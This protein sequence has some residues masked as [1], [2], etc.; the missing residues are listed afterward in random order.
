[1]SKGLW[2]T[3]RKLT[4]KCYENMAGMAGAAVS[5]DCWDKAF[6]VLQDIVA[7]G[8]NERA[9]YASELYQLDEMTD[10]EYDVQGWMEDYLDELDMREEKG[11]IL[12]VCDTLLG[13]FRW[14]EDTP[15]EIKLKKAMALYGLGE[16]AAAV[17]FC[18][19]WLEK[20]PDNIVTVTASVYAYTANGDMKEAEELIQGHIKE[21]TQCTEEND[22]LFTAAAAYY[23]VSG[24][25]KAYKRIDDALE[26]YDKY[27]EEFFLGDGE[28]DGFEWDDDD[29][30]FN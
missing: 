23:K 19:H 26:A 30:P 3:F 6:E 13:M 14:K 17:D 4:G 11:K 22:I 27:L 5:P 12:K 18:R 15:S 16:N 24:N 9:D 29:L 1:M 21:D 10:Y 7:E 25:K 28:D 2:K 20:E 8:R